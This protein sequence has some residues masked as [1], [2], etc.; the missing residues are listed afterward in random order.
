M[1]A[2]ADTEN[3][4]VDA[5]RPA[6][7]LLVAGAI[8]LLVMHWRHAVRNVYVLLDIAEH[9][10]IGRG[11]LEVVYN[12]ASRWLYRS[13]NLTISPVAADFSAARHA[14]TAAIHSSGVMIAGF[15]PWVMQWMK[16]DNSSRNAPE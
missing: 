2:A 7:R 8:I 14:A 6:N 9:R 1:S 10:E 15:L 4:Q 13:Y 16:Y 12:A 11:Y 3:L 5:P